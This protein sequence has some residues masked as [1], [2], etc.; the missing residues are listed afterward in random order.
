M[1]FDESNPPPNKK[2]HQARKIVVQEDGYLAA[3]L[4]STFP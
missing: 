3:I 2:S 4:N 1:S